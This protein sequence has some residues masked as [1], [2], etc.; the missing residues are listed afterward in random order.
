MIDKIRSAIMK[1][2]V[3]FGK[4]GVY[5][6]NGPDILPPPLTK[7][8]EARVIASMPCDENARNTLVEHNLRLVVYIAKKLPVVY[9]I[10]G[11]LSEISKPYN[12]EKNKEQ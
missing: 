6:I 10:L 7:E 1:L 9:V 2:A 4:K 12:L 5:Y 11:L 8:E 3:H